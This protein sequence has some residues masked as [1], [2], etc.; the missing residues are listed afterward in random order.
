MKNK[1]KF[2]LGL[3]FVLPTI[4]LGGCDNKFSTYRSA[5][6]GIELKY[7]KQWAKKENIDGAAVILLSPK[8]TPLDVYTEN[9]SVVVQQLSG[10]MVS[11]VEYTHLAITQLTQT[12]ENI[13]VLS[14]SNTFLG[15]RP[16]HRFEYLIKDKIQTKVIQIWTL[17]D[18]IAYQ[19][20]FACDLDRCEE[21]LPL[22]NQM[23]DSFILE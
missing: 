9:F 23:F 5:T 8:E 14:S 11:L 4:W 13:Q 17:K 2:Y 20:T 16:A 15:G 12:F 7:P 22:V 1:F 10:Q 18:K 19:V 3:I 21:Y 6:Y